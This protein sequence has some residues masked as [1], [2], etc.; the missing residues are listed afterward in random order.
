M[1]GTNREFRVGKWMNQAIKSEH[2]VNVDQ[3][4]EDN[5]CS[6]EDTAH[7]ADWAVEFLSHEEEIV[8]DDFVHMHPRANIFHTLEWRR[9]L[10]SAFGCRSM[11]LLCKDPHGRI[12]PRGVPTHFPV[13]SC[14]KTPE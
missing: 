11:Y 13:A 4:P 2:D 14:S 10:E 8:W 12:G 7:D 9:I 3:T 5:P 6:H 1:L